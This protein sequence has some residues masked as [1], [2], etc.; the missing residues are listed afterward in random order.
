[1]A[2]R[3]NSFFQRIRAKFFKKTPSIA[4]ESLRVPPHN[5]PIQRWGAHFEIVVHNALVTHEEDKRPITDPDFEK[6]D[7]L[8]EVDREIYEKQICDAA[9]GII[10][11]LGAP[12]QGHALYPFAVN[13]RRLLYDRK[14]RETIAKQ[15]KIKLI[16]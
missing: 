12:P 15:A 1:M 14:H 2:K 5:L 8:F 4:V 6:F 9:R 13:V 3:E 11:Y 10:D 16:D 7:V